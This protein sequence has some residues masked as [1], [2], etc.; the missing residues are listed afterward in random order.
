[1][2]GRKKKT[3]VFYIFIMLMP[4]I[5]TAVHSLFCNQ[6]LFL[7]KP[8]NSDE[9]CYWRVLYSF[10]ECGFDFASTCGYLNSEAPVGPLGEHGLSTLFAWGGAL[11]FG[12]VNEH[13]IFLWNLVTLSIALGMFCFIVKPDVV[14][15][16]WIII[17]IF[18]N[19]VLVEQWY[20]H[21]MEVPCL[22]I[23]LFYCA[24]EL[25]YERNRNKK[26]FY[27][28]LF[29]GAF[30]SFM[31]IC[32]IIIL[33]PIIIRF[34]KETK[35]G[36]KL[37]IYLAV[38]MICFVMIRITGNLFMK[39]SVSY[40]TSIKNGSLP[41]KISSLLFNF[42]KNA[43]LYLSLNNGSAIEIGQRYFQIILAVVL[44]IAAIT[45]RNEGEKI[46]PDYLTHAIS[47]IGLIF[48]I[49][50]LYDVESWRDVRTTMPY[51]VGVAIWFVVKSS[52]GITQLK[53][54]KL[55]RIGLLCGTVFSLLIFAPAKYQA[56]H[57]AD[58]FTDTTVDDSWIKEI[59]DESEIF[60]LY[61][62]N[63]SSNDQ[64]NLFKNLPP[65]VGI[66]F[67]RK[68]EDIIISQNTIKY[69]LSADEIDAEHFSLMNTSKDYGLLYCSDR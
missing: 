22:A 57:P 35:A 14:R 65:H 66:L 5:I 17:F 9:F 49:M 29:V 63:L 33:F 3:Y 36:K 54:G 52:S 50:L 39:S 24:L 53:S 56:N 68:Y 13:T 4:F 11:L 45:G 26:V 8:H 23:I 67:A 7:G 30:A 46:N 51:S 32:Y 55:L 16:F 12:K 6:N 59:P 1:M 18:G 20:S 47:L 19:G 15:A 44:I 43:G 69:I 31:R 37:Y 2:L 61:K 62:S 38:Y 48:M 27:L 28:A 41:E 64:F 42:R 58:R 40:L 21:M 10:S 25:E 60:C 34:A